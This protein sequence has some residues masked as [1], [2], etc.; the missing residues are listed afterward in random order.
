MAIINAKRFS[1]GGTEGGEEREIDVLGDRWFIFLV[2]FIFLI[3]FLSFFQIILFFYFLKIC[4]V[5]KF[6]F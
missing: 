1:G 3:R 2:I 4:D 6:K 5:L